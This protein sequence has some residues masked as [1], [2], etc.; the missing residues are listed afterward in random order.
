M[1]KRWDLVR[2]FMQ[3]A[4]EP[5]KSHAAFAMVMGSDPIGLPQVFSTDA[6]SIEPVPGIF[7]GGS[8]GR[9]N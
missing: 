1:K 9:G 5:V 6:K 8:L 4:S 7:G 3:H 2:P